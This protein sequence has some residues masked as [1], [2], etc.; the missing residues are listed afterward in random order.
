MLRSSLLMR[1]AGALLVLLAA[2][3]FSPTSE[4]QQQRGKA[5]A[6]AA[7]GGGD[8]A[9]RVQQLESQIVEMRVVIDTLESMARRGPQSGPPA[10]GGT[11]DS[12]GQGNARIDILETQVRALTTQIEQLSADVKAMAGR[13]GG[14]TPPTNSAGGWQTRPPQ[15][16]MAGPG[17]EVRGFDSRADPMGNNGQGGGSGPGVD[18]AEANRSYLQA[19]NL[20][21][22]DDF[23][24]ARDAIAA[25][26]KSYPDHPQVPTAQFRLG[27]SNYKLGQYGVAAKQFWT[28]VRSYPNEPVA[29]DSFAMFAASLGRSGKTKDACEAYR[30]LQA[31]YPNDA[32]HMPSDASAERARL[33][34]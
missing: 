33:G 4:A 5:G 10:A 16:T 9:E 19:I 14:G 3:T 23:G 27:Q 7:S 34:C 31:R 17:P 22:Q 6:T 12:Q 28:V 13:S 15:D 30:Q 20:Y 2:V 29:P 21:N 18:S 1:M 24:G 11:F 26:I 8:L 32:A 25:F